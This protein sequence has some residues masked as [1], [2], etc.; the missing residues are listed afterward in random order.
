MNTYGTEEMKETANLILLM[1]RFFD[2][3]NVRSEQEGHRTRNLDLLPYKDE[4]DPRLKV[5]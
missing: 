1:N 2:C 5:S 3:L 4:N